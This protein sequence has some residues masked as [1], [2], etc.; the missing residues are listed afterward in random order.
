MKNYLSYLIQKKATD[1]DYKEYELDQKYPYRINASLTYE[2][3]KKTYV[4][5]LCSWRNN[6]LPI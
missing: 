4:K 3:C 1:Q 6:R 5:G 2:E